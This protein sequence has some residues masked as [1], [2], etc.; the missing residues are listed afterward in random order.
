M[1]CNILS[2]VLVTCG[3]TAS[4][5]GVVAC[6]S[7]RGSDANPNPATRVSDEPQR[8]RE[9]SR[10]VDVVGHFDYA[11]DRFAF[12]PA[13][14]KESFRMLESLALERVTRVLGES[15]TKPQWIVSGVVTE[16][17]GINYLLISKAVMKAAPPVDTMP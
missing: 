17:R 3:T 6:G 11:G 13:D 14:N 16:Y 4:L 1:R 5:L 2:I 15:G 8:L 7:D 9:G 10:L 12:F